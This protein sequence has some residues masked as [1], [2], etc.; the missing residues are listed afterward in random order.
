MKFNADNVMYEKIYYA[1]MKVFWRHLIDKKYSFAGRGGIFPI[2]KIKMSD[3]IGKVIIVSSVY[4]TRTLLDE[5]INGEMKTTTSFCSITNYTKDYKE[6]GGLSLTTG[7]S[8]IIDNN[9]TN[10][11]FMYSENLSDTNTINNSKVDLANPDFDD[12]LKYGVQFVMMSLFL[13]DDHL[14][15]SYKYFKD[16]DFKMVLKAKSL[17]HI[18]TLN[19]EVKQQNPLLSYTTKEYNIPISGFFSTKK[20]G[21]TVTNT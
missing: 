15:K 7:S 18:E 2:G 21:V 8:T 16:R 1:L 14:Y 19:E 4:P 3:A 12:C 13:P 20:S 9:K 6:Y 11:S 10:L 17:R 5:I